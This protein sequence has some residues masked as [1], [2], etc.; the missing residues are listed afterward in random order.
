VEAF[1]RGTRFV[2]SGETVET[3]LKFGEVEAMLPETIFVLCHRAYMV[4]LAEIKCIRRY[5]FTLKSGLAV[6]IGKGRYMEIHRKF[7]D[8]IAD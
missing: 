8:Y 1:D 7:M 4:N 6:P 2:L 5:E 3:K